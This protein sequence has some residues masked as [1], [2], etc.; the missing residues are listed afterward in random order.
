MNKTGSA[1]QIWDLLSAM[2]RLRKGPGAVHGGAT[3]FQDSSPVE[4]FAVNTH[5]LWTQKVLSD[6]R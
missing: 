6:R 1:V 4:E 5:K 2:Q 3:V